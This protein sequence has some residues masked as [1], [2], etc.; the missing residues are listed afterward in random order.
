MIVEKIYPSPAYAK[1][2]IITCIFRHRWSA[3]GIPPIPKDAAELH[4]V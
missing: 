4:I 2:I 3:G 1:F